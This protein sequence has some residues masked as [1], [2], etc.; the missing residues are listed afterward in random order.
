MLFVRRD[1]VSI[2]KQTILGPIWFLLQPLMTTIVFTIIFGRVAKISTDDVPPM[3]FYMGGTVVWTYFASCINNTSR[4]FI[5]SAQIFSKVYFPRL[6]VPI[7]IVLSNLISFALQFVFFLGFFVFF[8][9]RGFDVHLTGWAFYTPILILQMAALG[10][11]A[12]LIISAMTTK[13]RDLQFVVSFGVQL[14]MYATPIV[15]PL[16]VAP[17]RWRWVIS[18][19]PMAPVVETFRHAFLGSGSVNIPQLGISIV[20]T[21]LI[22][23]GGIIIFNKVEK[24]FVDTV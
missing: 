23:V 5:S 12:G 15:Y 7:S 19:N 16:S 6:C 11:G 21:T 9:I 1:F 13:Y 24:H 18:L 10:L 4:T 22:L 2:Y 8:Y 14:W 17:P 20:V 3:L